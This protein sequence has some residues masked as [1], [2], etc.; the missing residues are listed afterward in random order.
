MVGYTLVMLAVA[1][2][3]VAIGDA[4]A[5][6]MLLLF[7]P[8]WLLPWP[9][10]LLLP[11]VWRARWWVR[12]VA[13]T[14]ALVTL[15]GVA[16]WN[17]PRSAL[18]LGIPDPVEPSL[19]VVTWNTDGRDLGPDQLAGYLARWDA[20][21]VLLQDCRGDAL[22]AL[23][24]GRRDLAAY[25]DGEFCVISRLPARR[26]AIAP[27]QSRRDGRAIGFDVAWGGRTVR[28]VTVHLPSPRD[29]LGAARNGDPSKLAFSV[30]QR[31]AA[32][33][34]LSE[35][36]LAGARQA[37]AIIVAGDFNDEPNAVTT[38]IV[39][40]TSWKREDRG[41]RDCMLFNALDVEQ[42]LV[43]ARGRD[44]AFTIVH[45]G[46]PERIDHVLVSEEFVPHSRH[47]VGYVERVEVLNDHL[48]ERRRGRAPLAAAA[49]QDGPDLG[50]ILSDHAAV[51]VSIVLGQSLPR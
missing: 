6:G 15:L 17:V 8:R 46:E 21:V 42:R 37:D 20:H 50:R 22:T 43:P 41:Q 13:V 9:W 24:R 40:D 12:G 35:W 19:R 2:A 23:A 1:A 5:P 45:A 44:V 16:L 29:E 36:A 18:R 10:L 27:S 14:G 33:L 49:G 32:S 4:N 30:A 38:Q 39:A 34:R 7:G 31:S 48:V 47:A 25:R 51:C 11:L 26:L 28:V 3:I